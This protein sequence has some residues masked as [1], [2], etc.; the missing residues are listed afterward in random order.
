MPK[1]PRCGFAKRDSTTKPVGKGTTTVNLQG[2]QLKIPP[3][4]APVGTEITLSVPASERVEVH[5]QAN[6]QEHFQFDAPVELTISY[7][8]CR[9]EDLPAGDIHIFRLTDDGSDIQ[10]DLGGKDDRRGKKVST[11]LDH[12]SGYLIGG[13]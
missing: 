13:G 7:A 11:D 8:R 1:I 5:V 9:D 6:G 12:L 3:G 4:A 2:H 10:E